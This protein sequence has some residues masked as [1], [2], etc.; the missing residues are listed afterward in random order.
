MRQRMSGTGPVKL[1]GIA[2]R[3]RV[4]P[5][6]KNTKA[7]YIREPLKIASHAG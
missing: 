2:S 4:S 6:T 7:G 3:S 5:G 1:L